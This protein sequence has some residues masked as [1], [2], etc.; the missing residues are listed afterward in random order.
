MFSVSLTS[1]NNDQYVSIFSALPK[2]DSLY[3]NLLPASGLPDL[4]LHT[5]ALLTETKI[6][7]KASTLSTLI[8]PNINKPSKWQSSQAQIFNPKHT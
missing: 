5:S 2:I 6:R 7:I 3:A 1:Y 8:T 4:A